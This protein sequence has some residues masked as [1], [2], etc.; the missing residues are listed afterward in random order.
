[1]FVSVCKFCN[2]LEGWEHYLP[3]SGPFDRSV[4][5]RRVSYPEQ[6]GGCLEMYY[7][8]VELNSKADANG[9]AKRHTC[10][11]ICMHFHRFIQGNA[12]SFKFTLTSKAAA[13]PKFEE[14]GQCGRVPSPSRSSISLVAWSRC[15][16]ESLSSSGHAFFC[17]CSS[18]WIHVSLLVC[19]CFS[20][21]L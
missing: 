3:L 10:A 16:K 5:R 12:I 14:T 20:L 19:F 1:M 6:I 18:F 8:V 4:I 7:S 21:L 17:A 15:S 9:L 2:Y 11:Q 13:E